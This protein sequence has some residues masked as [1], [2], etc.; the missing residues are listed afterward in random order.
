MKLRSLFV[1]VALLLRLGRT[2]GDAV[3]SA[4]LAL[5][6]IDYRYFVAGGTC[7]AISHGLTTPIDVVKTRIQADPAKYNKG[8]RQATVA[9]IQEDGPQ[10]LL[11]GLGPTVVGYGI[12]GAMK[13]GVYEIC[14]PIFNALFLGSSS[15]EKSAVAFLLASITAGAIAALILCPMESTRIRIVTDPAFAGKGLLTGLS[16][17][18]TEEGLWSTFS[19][20]WAMLAKQVPYTFG[21]QVS[22]DVF[23]GFLYAFFQSVEVDW[24]GDGQT[25]WM[26]SI[27]AAFM[28]SII[29][30]IFSQP[31]DMLLT[32]TYRPRESQKKMKTKKGKQQ[33]TDDGLDRSF[34]AVSNRIYQKGGM[35]G[36]F[37]GTGAR[38][39]HVGMIITSQLV[40]YDLVKQMLGL[41]ATGSH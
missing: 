12:E 26:V 33:V 29:A 40:I 31:G 32:E 6:S 1:Q 20:L 25:K 41:P 19:G 3:S 27:M 14:K 37:T 4:L 18:V 35:S 9:I 5:K 2:N 22:F 7:A 23:A 34:G 36:F 15:E 8:M 28:A 17:L 39:V 11:G 13:F 30:C 24:L 10:V 21:K 38:I 16:K